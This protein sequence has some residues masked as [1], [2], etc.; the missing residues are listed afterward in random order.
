M[1]Q[2]RSLLTLVMVCSLFFDGWETRA[3]DGEALELPEVV[4]L[5]FTNSPYSFFKGVELPSDPVDAWQKPGFDD[6]AWFQEL[7]TPFSYGESLDFG[8]ILED[9]QD[10]YTTFL[11]RHSFDLQ[12]PELIT[13]LVVNAAIDDGFIAWVNGH[14]L[15]RVNVSDQPFGIGYTASTVSEPVPY[16]RYEI[17][18]DDDVLLFGEN[19]L[20]IQVV[21]GNIASSDIFFEISLDGVIGEIENLPPIPALDPSKEAVVEDVFG[22]GSE[23]RFFR[24]TAEPSDPI[25]RWRLA[26]FDDADWE[27]GESPLFY[28]EAVERGTLIDDMQGNYTS[29][30]LRRSFIVEAEH[31]DRGVEVSALVDDGLAVWIN[32]RELGR[33]GVDRGELLFDSEASISAEEPLQATILRSSSDLLKPGVNWI[34]VQVLNGSPNSSDFFIDLKLGVV[35]APVIPMG[36]DWLFFPGDREPNSELGTSWQEIEYD[37]SEWLQGGAPFVTVRGRDGGTVVPGMLGQFGS[38]FLRQSF[39]LNHPA[40][41]DEFEIELELAHGAALWVNGIEILRRNLAATELGLEAVALRALDGPF[42]EKIAINV[43]SGLL[44]TGE[45]VIAARAV[46]FEVENVDFRF[47][48]RMDVEGLDATTPSLVGLDPPRGRVSDLTEIRLVFSEKV[49][50]I[51]AGDLKVN[52][53]AARDVI[54]GDRE[55]TFLFDEPSEWPANILFEP[56]GSIWDLAPNSNSFPFFQTE[57]VYEREDFDP[58]R[59]VEILPPPGVEV[60]GLSELQLQF[61]EP[62]VGLVSDRII[63]NGVPALSLVETRPGRF[64]VQFDVM[65]DSEVVIELV[66]EDAIFDVSGNQLQSIDPW[67]YGLSAADGTEVFVNEVVSA[68]YSGLAD[69]DGEYEDWIELYNGGRSSVNLKGW[70]MTDDPGVPRKWLFPE[71]EIAPNDYLVIFASGKNRSIGMGARLHTN[72]KLGRGG[73]AVYLF[74]PDLPVVVESQSVDPLPELRDG[75]SFGRDPEGA[76]RFFVDPT[77]GEANGVSDLSRVTSSV[78]YSVERGLFESPFLLTLTTEDPGAV[79]RYTRD[80]SDPSEVNGDVYSEWIR[81]DETTIVRAAAFSDGALPS[82]I[83]SESYLFTDSVLLGNLPVFSLATAETN[84]IGPTGILGIG[85][86]EYIP[87]GR[88]DFVWSSV[89]PDDYHNPTKRGIEWERPVSVEYFDQRGNGFQL[90]GGFRVHGSVF[91]RPKLR[92]DSKFGFRLYF[93][94]DYKQGAVNFPVI[95]EVGR[96]SFDR[97]VLRS[98]HND[99]ENPFISDEVMRRLSA[100][101]GRLTSRGGFSHLFLNGEYQGYYNHVERIEVSTLQEWFGGGTD[102]DIVK[103]FANLGE[104]DLDEWDEM[105]AFFSEADMSLPANYLEASRHLDVASFIDYILVNMYGDTGDWVRS[106]WRAVREETPDSKFRFLV[107]DAEFSLGIYDRPVDVNT[108]ELPGELGIPTFISLFMDQLKQSEEF[109]LL[110]ADRVQ[111]HFFNEG[112]LTDQAIIAT[113]EK[114]RD[115]VVSVIPEFRTHIEET[116]IPG[117][118]GFMLGHLMDAGLMGLASTPTLSRGGGGVPAGFGLSIQADTGDEVYYTLDGNDPRVAIQGGPSPSARRYDGNPIVLVESVDVR[119]RARRDGQWSALS[120]GRFSV[121]ANDSGIS[122]SEIH[123]HPS[124]DSSPEFLELTNRSGDTVNLSGAQFRGIGFEFPVES[125]MPSGAVWVLVREEDHNLFTARYPD[126][127]VAGLFSGKLSNKGELIQLSSAFGAFL[128]GVDYDDS[129]GWPSQ[130][131]GEG[132][133]LELKSLTA[134]PNDPTQWRASDVLGGTPGVYSQNSIAAVQLNEVYVAVVGDG[135]DR[136]FVEL[137][138]RSG[139]RVELGNWVL[140]S[141]RSGE[142]LFEFSDGFGIDPEE[143]LLV[144]LGMAGDRDEG[145]ATGDLFDESE[146]TAMLLGPNGTVVDSVRYG[147]QVVGSSLI[148]LSD[149]AW[150]L[151]EPSPGLRNRPL[152]L[153]SPSQFVINEWQTNP[154]NGEDDWFE[155]FN[156]DSSRPGALRGLTFSD[157]ESLVTLRSLVF[158]PAGGFVRLWADK[159]S[160][161]DHLPFRLASGGGKIEIISGDFEVLDSIA[162]ESQVEG[163]STGYVP[164]GSGELVRFPDGGSPGKSNVQSMVGDLVLSEIL[165]GNQAG[166]RGPHGGFSTYIEVA[167]VGSREQDL[168]GK[169]LWVESDGLEWWPFPSGSHLNPGERRVIWVDR[170]LPVSDGA[171][172]YF[173]V[174][175]K[176]L[177]A[178]GQVS[179]VGANGSLLDSIRFGQQ[180]ADLSLGRTGSDWALRIEPSPGEEESVPLELTAPHTL[181]INEWLANSPDGPDWIELYNSE[182]QVVGLGGL[183]LSDEPGVLGKMGLGINPYTYIGPKSWAVIGSSRRFPIGEQSVLGFSLAREGEFIRLYD[184][185]GRLIDSV[186]FSRQASGRSEGRLPDGGD[187]FRSPLFPSPFGSNVG[188]ET[189]DSDQDG[190]PDEWELAYGLDPEDS[191]DAFLDPDQDGISNLD[192]Y[193]GGSDPNDELEMII[194]SIIRSANGVLLQFN[195]RENLRYRLEYKTELSDD[196]WDL[197]AEFNTVKGQTLFDYLDGSVLNDVSRYYRLIRP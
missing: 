31:L 23:W 84:I 178:G 124:D 140:V 44:K 67:R 191:L 86:G 169:V 106:N 48:L 166:V 94:S 76:W 196:Q 32:G 1:E 126:V 118:R 3:Q 56:K 17:D 185:N 75:V 82:E 24:G 92:P 39:Y 112:A 43:P 7:F 53:V 114:A 107:W 72:F 78:S 97:I 37:D 113:Y 176:P 143:L 98:G 154:V 146:D 101:M 195:V 64:E 4:N 119:V 141:L 158:V 181:K 62:I 90:D 33:S 109:R 179:L 180:I 144:E 54:R 171:N 123:Y 85:G 6:G 175:N 182:D 5:V 120:E 21:N 18:L 167:N 105:V 2:A 156:P 81:I 30:Y 115:E 79:I 152:E 20:G 51:E 194:A 13:E 49:Y 108:L 36:S 15:L 96:S 147:D 55:F 184:S 50:G 193:F 139:E 93:R 161:P 177:P 163:E 29:I 59:L 12:N 28:G 104:G 116:W 10:N 187:L 74:P 142:E 61:D 162:Y 173:S 71:L 14:E 89:N 41:I 27:R 110:F 9:M 174:T 47:D 153:A 136:S 100:N 102:W 127:P 168:G 58:P 188:S 83:G 172:H 128:T 111:K 145:R 73:D 148:R 117:R 46:N 8:T 190:I 122:I 57:W 159:G 69:E 87:R 99:F 66:E 149:G 130:A 192:E 103:P 131:D 197:E 70:S 63:A 150:N 165:W 25:D 91:A 52:G 95:E 186:D 151:G 60:K 134:D 170:D 45:N 125:L 160:G 132:P 38:V 121:G 19:V 11:L 138:N 68:S 34:A 80:G 157:G 155:I 40:L 183:V 22:F 164:D 137:I 189:L 135:V 129:K 42:D 16:V 88:S 65:L 26:E 133:S 77:P 35:D